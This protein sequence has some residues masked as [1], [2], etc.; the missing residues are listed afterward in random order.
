MC[1][2]YC[3]SESS[4][5]RHV[6]RY[7]RS[8]PHFVVKCKKCNYECKS[9][10]YFK[11]HSDRC[12]YSSND[13]PN[14][15]LEQ[16]E[17]SNF[18]EETESNSNT[19]ILP[20]TEFNIASFILKLEATQGLGQN[21]INIIVSE[22]S[23]LFED[24]LE[25]FK[26]QVVE[27]LKSR[28][29]SVNLDN[30]F[31]KNQDVIKDVEKKLNSAKKR[32]KYYAEKFNLIHPEPV[33]MN[34]DITRINN[35]LCRV[36]NYAYCVPFLESLK[37][38][39]EIPEILYWVKNKHDSKD[40]LSRDWC[41]GAYIKTL[42][43]SSPNN[44]NTI[45][46]ILHIDDMET[47][48]PIGMS[49][50]KHKLTVVSYELANVPP[51]FRSA[52]YKKQLLAI[53][54]SKFVKNNGLNSLLLD[55]VLTMN[56]LSKG[57]TLKVNNE[58][59]L[60]NAFLVGTPADTPASN[61]LW[62]F[63]E[64]VA[65]AIKCCRTCDGQRPD[66]FEKFK[67]ENFILRT[68]DEHLDRCDLMEEA[69][70]KLKK[71]L[72]KKYGINSKSILFNLKEISLDIAIH[73]PMHVLLEGVVIL[74]I[75]ASLYHFIFIDSYFSL[76]WLNTQLSNWIY[77]E[78]QVKPPMF[79]ADKLKGDCKLTLTAATVLTLIYVLPF[80]LSL[81]VP[82][83]NEKFLNLIRLIK[84]TNICTSPYALQ[85][86]PGQLANL[87]VK[88][89]ETFK[90]EYPTI[91]LTPKFHYLIHF[92]RQIK[93][94]GPLRHQWCMRWEAHFSVLK[95]RKWGSFKNISYSMANF[96]QLWS[97]YHQ[98]GINGKNPNYL[99]KGHSITYDKEIGISNLDLSTR[100]LLEPLIDS[101]LGEI[102]QA[103]EVT[104]YGC[105]FKPGV[106]FTNNGY[107]FNIIDKIFVQGDKILLATKST[108]S[109]NFINNLNSFEV[110][111]ENNIVIVDLL[112]I[113]RPFPLHTV[114]WLSKKYI[115]NPYTCEVFGE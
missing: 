95:G 69:S 111:F 102:Y 92:P 107:S 33:F 2:Y 96:H 40:I 99:Y 13:S 109:C 47:V 39:L 35:K 54:K 6:N 60:C 84:I 63:K 17:G 73:D 19:N 91:T 98:L 81:K 49:K 42:L 100:N 105:K 59:I 7:H 41:D 88:H 12:N 36:N 23:A 93:N 97:C 115:V 9:W 24:F 58:N 67:E 74:E 70:C 64:G 86:T 4:L 45:L 21:C 103:K 26:T 48:N 89:N 110:L 68:T 114:S 1:Y 94:F 83:S 16:F 82:L 31:K 25:G 5:T 28:N 112:S 72:S 101:S 20:N 34:S 108:N 3:N 50:K 38:Q 62:G 76:K 14:L 85:V 51:Q 29:V 53:S 52:V 113:S 10:R 87:I 106:S 15:E 56:D 27:E 11:R 22:F 46:I 90:I 78:G 43:K 57:L 61:Q 32:K 37:A 66:I 18:N 77:H 79:E 44:M 30:I 104:Y 80:I 55:F 71:D 75:K 8:D 65:K